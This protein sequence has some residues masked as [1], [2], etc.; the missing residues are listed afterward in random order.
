[1]LNVSFIGQRPDGKLFCTAYRGV[2][3]DSALLSFSQ[4]FPDSQIRQFRC[5]GC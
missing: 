1:M 2:T 4:E 3:L 5:W